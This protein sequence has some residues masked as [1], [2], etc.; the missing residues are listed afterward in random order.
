MLV[1]HTL[2]S[3]YSTPRSKKRKVLVRPAPGRGPPVPS[4]AKKTNNKKAD[5]PD[6][7]LIVEVLMKFASEKKPAT[8]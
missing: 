5:Y 3:V 2:P 8:L 7:A 1:L 4:M 6:P